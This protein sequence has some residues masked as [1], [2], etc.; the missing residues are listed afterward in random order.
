MYQGQPWHRYCKTSDNRVSRLIGPNGAYPD[1]A[2]L[3]GIYCNE[4]V[5]TNR[6]FHF[7]V[8]ANYK[9]YNV[10][11]FQQSRLTE[12]SAIILNYEC[13]NF[14]FR[15]YCE[16]LTATMAAKR[17]K[18]Q[19]IRDILKVRFIFVYCFC[20]HMSKWYMSRINFRTS[21]ICVTLEVM[22]RCSAVFAQ[23]LSP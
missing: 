13:D 21:L 8:V 5:R 6:L 14:I 15:V 2:R 10:F 23:L 12:R 17:R 22:A 7:F 11:L 9:T 20:F 1:V 19:I 3:S 16:G 18:C 4:F